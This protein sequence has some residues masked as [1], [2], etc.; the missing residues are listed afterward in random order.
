VSEAKRERYERTT[1][2]E[3]KLA[4]GEDLTPDE[5]ALF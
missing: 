2:A 4:R 1:A 5:L 3:A